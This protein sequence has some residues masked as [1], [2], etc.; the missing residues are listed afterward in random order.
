MKTA[1]ITGSA[2]LIGS[3]AAVFFASKGYRIVGIDND[4][5][6]YFFGEEASTEWNRN[7]LKERLGDQYEH[8]AADIRDEGSLKKIF[9]SNDFDIVIHT[10]AQPSHDWA[11]KEPITDFDIN[12]RATLLILEMCR[13]YCPHATFIFTSTNKVYG[14]NPNKLPLVEL[15]KRYEIAEDHEYKNGI[16]EFMSLDQTTH[17]VFGASKVAADVMVQEYGRYFKLNTAVFRGGCLT[18]P[19][20]SGAKLHG[21]LAYLV[22]CIIEEKPYTIFGYK[23]KQVRDNIHAFDLVN[24][25]WHFHQNPRPGEVYNAGGGRLSNIS[26]LEAIEKIEQLTGKKARVEYSE[27]NRIGDHIWYISDTSKF[28]SHY[29]E[30]KQ[31]HDIDSILKEICEQVSLKH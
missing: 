15:D 16:D 13:T 30:W 7:S 1:L 26:M 24:M 4:M 8:N 12:A 21:F 25:F 18:G 10:A 14:D 5:R 19:Q 29:P 27:D 3:E 23:G 9:E 22:K 2:G 17:S 28:Q 31:E 6:K 20:H 11:A